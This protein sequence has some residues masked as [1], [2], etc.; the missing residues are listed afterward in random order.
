MMSSSTNQFS[1]VAIFIK[2]TVVFLGLSLLFDRLM[3]A[4]YLIEQTNNATVS[5]TISFIVQQPKLLT[6]FLVPIC[7]LLALWTTASTLVDFEKTKGFQKDVLG[8]ISKV[9]AN[10]IYAAIAAMCL[11]PSIDSWIAGTG[12]SLQL[13]W[14]IEI[15]TIGMIGV[16]LKMLARRADYVQ[17]QLDAIV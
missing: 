5:S 1:N 15:V 14:D 6:G 17:R 7:L 3:P 13:Y 12:R 9:G 11:V 4:I 16:A 10:L 2:M 8:G